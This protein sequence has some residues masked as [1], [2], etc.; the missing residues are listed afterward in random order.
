MRTYIISIFIGIT[1]AGCSLPQNLAPTAYP[2]L[3]EAHTDK[4]GPNADSLNLN[5]KTYFKD[6]YLVQLID[7][8]LLF[9]PDL[10][11]ANQRIYASRAGYISNKNLLLP[12]VN[13]AV[14][15]GVTRFGDYTMDGVGNFDTNKSSNIREDQKIPNPV[16]DYYAGVGASWEVNFTGKLRNKKRAAINR[17]YA[18]EEGR[19]LLTTQL[20][21]EIA[22]TYY[23]LLALDT[24]LQII[25]KNIAL[26][27]KGLEIIQIQKQSG[28]INELAVKQF[29]AQAYNF[30]S[31][32]AQIKQE[33][34]N[35]EN[36]LN[37][38]SGR[39]P[40]S[41]ARKSSL[42]TL[43]LPNMIMAGV[44]AN[45]LQNRPDIAKAEKELD[46]SEFELKSAKA[47]F[48]PSLNITANMG[49]NAFASALW[50]NPASLAFGLLGSLSAPALN[51]NQVM[52]NYRNSYVEKNQAILEFQKVMLQAMQEVSTYMNRCKN[53]KEVAS[54]KSQE[55]KT[56][57]EAVDISNQL[58]VTGYANYLEVLLASQNKLASEIQ[59]A[60]A[61]KE[62]FKASVMLYRS[63]GGG[64]K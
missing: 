43:D 38:L 52:L 18:S 23:D 55:V 45:L 16:P 27:D 44:P 5:W 6:P 8:A 7:T 33:I 36:Y 62:Q 51:R 11:K 54:Y 59:L 37:Y 28:R 47:S 17:Y 35:A 57:T 14:S 30:K 15:T 49:Y 39:Y 26:Q 61:R 3:P 4:P 64:W 41:V 25:K 40:Q 1:L 32:E 2:S 9:N 48:Y 58:F 20:V 10:Q 50:F 53:Y 29:K 19:K 12:Q 31:L 22:N 21:A 34:V 42:D 13:L 46:A 24:E 60:E 56:L 63:L